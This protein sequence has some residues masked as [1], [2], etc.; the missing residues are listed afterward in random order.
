MA[1]AVVL[2]LEERRVRCDV[3][4]SLPEP[5]IVTGVGGAVSAVNASVWVGRNWIE[6]HVPTSSGFKHDESSSDDTSDATKLIC[7]VGVNEPEQT[8]FS[9][10]PDTVPGQ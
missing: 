10:A 3:G 7:G 8:R 5:T 2:N 4:Q 1:L 6:L 9:V